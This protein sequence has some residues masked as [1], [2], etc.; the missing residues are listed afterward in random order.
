MGPF[1]SGDLVSVTA[2][3]TTDR[4]SALPDTTAASVSLAPGTSPAAEDDAG[5]KVTALVEAVRALKSDEK[6]VA[7]SSFV[8]VLEAAQTTLDGVGIE[9][10]VFSGK[11]SD[12][13]RRST[14][15]AFG[16]D[17]GPKVLLC[18][19]KAGGVGVDFTRAN[20]A[21]LLDTWW[22]SAAEEQ[23]LARVHRIGQTR[24][25]TCVRI[26]AKRTVEERIL[27]LQKAKSALGQ[28]ALARP[29][30]EQGRDAQPEDI[31]RLF[32]PFED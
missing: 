17:A 20:H 18:S 3:A 25:C 30:A 15:A 14:L 24:P 31:T 1:G 16:G 11:L 13:S 8:T 21:Y 10:V 23:A 27:A 29:S 19:L 26:V 4:E 28:G 9:S 2:V 22:N 7:F 5:P 6:L 32:E 12:T